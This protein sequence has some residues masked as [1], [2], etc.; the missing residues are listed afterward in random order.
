MCTFSGCEDEYKTFATRKLWEEHEFGQ[1]RLI[2]HWACAICQYKAGSP[3]GWRDHLVKAHQ[4]PFRTG[5]YSLD[6]RLVE[7]CVPVPTESLSCSLCLVVPGKSQ[8][9][10]ATHVG[11]HMEGIALAALPRD[12]E[13]T[14]TES[15]SSKKT[16]QEYSNHDLGD[17]EFQRDEYGSSQAHLEF[18]NHVPSDH[19]RAVQSPA[20]GPLP[21]T[22]KCSLAVMNSPCR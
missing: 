15:N 11:K 12:G 6:P 22:C 14:D 2:R 17:N 8:R 13:S 21:N 7:V 18:K 4:R 19:T 20:I 16:G 10:F 1:H 3:E 9:N 5:G